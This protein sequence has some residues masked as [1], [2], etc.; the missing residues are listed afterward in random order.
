MIPY[1]NPEKIFKA[2]EKYKAS[3]ILSNDRNVRELEKRAAEYTGAKYAVATSSGTMALYCVYRAL[4]LA[5]K[6]VYM[7]SFT[8][9]STA[10]SAIMAGAKPCFC[11]ITDSDFCLDPDAVTPQFNDCAALCANDCFGAPANY[12]ELEKICA[13]SQMPFIIDSASAFGAFLDV[14]APPCMAS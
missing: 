12:A 2:P 11:D 4:G 3:R 9:R 13:L 1:V 8:W 10:E 6:R 7:P 5:G 14:A